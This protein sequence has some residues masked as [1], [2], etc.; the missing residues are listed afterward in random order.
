MTAEEI[1]TEMGVKTPAVRRW[2]RAG[3]L[4]AHIIDGCLRALYER[5]DFN[6]LR[7]L[8]GSAGAWRRRR[9][10]NSSNGR[11]AV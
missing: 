4:R 11:R 7:A 5:P 6:E 1:A 8:V 10:K 2:K 9:S 3:L